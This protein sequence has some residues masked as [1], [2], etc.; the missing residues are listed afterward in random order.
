MQSLFPNDADFEVEENNQESED[1]KGSYLFDFDKGEFVTNPDGSIKRCNE[2]IAYKQ[3]CQK[4]LLTPRYTKLSYPNYYGHDL[5]ELINSGLTR[6]AIELEIERMVK[7]ALMVHPKTKGVNAFKFDWKTNFEVYFSC[8]VVTVD[9]ER[10]NIG[11][12]IR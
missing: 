8:E 4:A 7:E 11:N 5:K 2:K 9:D 1:F 10:I 12:E 6:S 3:W